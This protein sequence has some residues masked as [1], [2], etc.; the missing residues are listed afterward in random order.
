MSTFPNE[1]F[2]YMVNKLLLIGWD[3]ADWKVIEPLM[4]QG[5]MPALERLMSNGVFGRIQTLDPPLSPMLWTSIATGFRADKHGITGFVEPTPDGSTLQPVTSTSRRVKAIWNI[6][7]QNGYKSNVVGWWPSNPVEPINGAMVSNH[8]QLATKPMDE[9]WPITLGSVHPQELEDVLAALRVH[10]HE[11]TMNMVSPFVPN[12]RED[13]ALRTTKQVASVMKVIAESATLHACG[14]HLM[15][16]TE[17]DFMAVYYDAIDHFSHIAMKY[18]PPRRDFIPEKDFEDYRHIVE[19]AYKF[20]DMMLERTLEL[21]D[22]DTTIVLLSD[23]GFHPDHLRPV[24]IP[25][26]PSGPAVEHSPYGIIVMSGPGI[27]TGGERIS[28]ASVIDITPTILT[29]FGLPVGKDMEGRILTQAIDNQV[30]PSYIDSWETVEGD[31]GQHSSDMTQDPWASQ[32]AMQQ[33]VELGYIESPGDDK[34]NQVDKARR[35][36]RYYLARNIIQGG[37]LAE[38]IKIL[39]EIYEESRIDRFGNR[40]AIAYINSKQ[41]QKATALL[42]TLKEEAQRD[43]QEKR[44][45]AKEEDTF[46]NGE[47]EAPVSL[48][49]IEGLLFLAKNNPFKALPLLEKVQLTHPTNSELHG[50]IAHIY[51]MRMSYQHAEKQYIKSLAINPENHISHHGLGVCLLRTNRFEE[52][53]EEFLECIALNPF[54]VRAHY[55]LGEALFHLGLYSQSEEAFK[56]ALALNLGITKAHEWLARL[57]AD[58]LSNPDLVQYHS[59]FIQK[60]IK[61][62]VIV[63]SGLPRS[64]TSMMMKM[65]AA[66]GVQVLVDEIRP[67]DKSNPD[68]Y[69]EYEKVKKIHLDNTWM[70]EATGKVVKIISPLL[71]HLPA[72]LNYKIVLMERDMDEVLVSQQK[73]LGKPA[74]PDVIPVNLYMAMQNQQHKADAWLQSEPN[75]QLIRINYSDVIENPTE[76][77]HSVAAFVGL[78]LDV[79]AM[80]AAVNPELYRNKF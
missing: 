55:H 16:N 11:L 80:I 40:L 7:N 24:W 70:P 4:K 78:E 9:E 61:G 28:G 1:I 45:S 46:N 29:L 21:V 74:N 32:M 65:L 76:I 67:A 54:Y 19:A 63:V 20:Q 44:E 14:T 72:N 48:D 36:S 6:L 56:S 13:E 52:A 69:F 47:F 53:A 58:H 41:Y 39:E 51:M 23:H 5:K 66:G 71:N 25:N 75:V 42:E 10:P 26:E 38:G 2:Y 3:A 50:Q 30:T 77:A 73:M 37:K 27:K 22:D 59:E 64:G 17:W 18:H 33:L 43:A 31:T 34:L 79:D 12:L 68:G 57:Y 15:Q 60:N 8:F 62:E 35:E 49:L